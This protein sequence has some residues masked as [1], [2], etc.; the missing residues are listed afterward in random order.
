MIKEFADYPT[1]LRI[2][3][4]GYHESLFR[5]YHILN[6]VKELLSKNT[7]QEVIL[8]IIAEIETLPMLDKDD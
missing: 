3:K 8:E 7:P 1:T 2:N 5:S 6:K 4:H